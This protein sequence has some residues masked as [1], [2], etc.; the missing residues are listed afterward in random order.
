MLTINSEYPSSE[1]QFESKFQAKIYIYEKVIGKPEEYLI[2][3]KE[4][5]HYE[6]IKFSSEP[7]QNE[8][9]IINYEHTSSAYH[10]ERKSKLRF[11]HMR[12]V[13][14]NQKNI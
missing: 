8:V 6:L 3:F 11:L 4:D 7:I 5:H 12:K 2:E 10:F 13:L 1:D 14:E 9:L